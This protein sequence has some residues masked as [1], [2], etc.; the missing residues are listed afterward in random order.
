VSAQIPALSLGITNT[1]AGAWRSRTLA[2]MLMLV[3]GMVFW[4]DSR[5]PA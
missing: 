4:V 3:I 2:V 1:S 5:Y